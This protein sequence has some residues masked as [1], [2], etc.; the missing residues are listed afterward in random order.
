MV[1]WCVKESESVNLF[2]LFRAVFYRSPRLVRAWPASQA[3]AGFSPVKRALGQHCGSV[4]VIFIVTSLVL[5]ATCN[6]L[7]ERAVR[8]RLSRESSPCYKRFVV[9]LYFFV[10]FIAS[11]PVTR[12]ASF[13]L[14]C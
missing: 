10:F 12:C 1:V 6:F 4:V 14:W 11:V 3:R 8:E 5:V 9:N 13:S 2:Q 7:L